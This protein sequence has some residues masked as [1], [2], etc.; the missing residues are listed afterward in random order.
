MIASLIDPEVSVY[1]PAEQIRRYI[2][3]LKQQTHTP[4]RD[5]AISQAKGWLQMQKLPIRS[6]DPP[7]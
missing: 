2:A 1:S 7:R 6:I 3:K 4:E 5:A